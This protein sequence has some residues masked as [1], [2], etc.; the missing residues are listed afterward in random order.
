MAFL[1]V[2]QEARVSFTV[3]NKSRCYDNVPTDG[4][5]V[6]FNPCLMPFVVAA[7]HAKA[8]D[9]T[10]RGGFEAPRRRSRGKGPPPRHGWRRDD[11][12]I[13]PQIRKDSGSGYCGDFFNS[14]RFWMF[15]EGRE[16]LLPQSAVAGEGSTFYFN[17]D[18]WTL[19]KGI[20]FDRMYLTAFV[21]AIVLCLLEVA[22][23][24]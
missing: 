15:V 8:K 10:H 1:T 9:V 7:A 18:P 6:T 24:S 11:S 14:R 2:P 20:A 13:V 4:D 21:P 23:W 22:C 3:D 16:H 19:F 12:R 5:T 17:A